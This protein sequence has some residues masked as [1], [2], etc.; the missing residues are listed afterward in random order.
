MAARNPFPCGN[1][2]ITGTGRCTAPMVNGIRTDMVNERLIWD[3]AESPESPYQALR[4][5]L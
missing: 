4:P 1:R 5:S 2:A 3:R